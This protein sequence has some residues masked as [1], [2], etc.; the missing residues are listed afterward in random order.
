MHFTSRGV[1]LAVS[2]LLLGLARLASAQ[3][4]PDSLRPPR[5]EAVSQLAFEK[6]AADCAHPLGL[7]EGQNREY[8]LL[9]AKGKPTGS[10]RY[11]VVKVSTD[12]VVAKKK[13]PVVVTSVRLKCGLYDLANGVLQQQDL[14]Y[15]C[16][17]D[18][19]FTD[20][21]G[22]INYDGLKGFRDRRLTYEGTPLAWPNQPK[23]GTRL[24]TGGA[25]VLVSSPSVAIGR[26]KTTLLQRRVLAGPTAVTVPAGTFTCYAVESQRELATAARAD[27]V[28]KN[29]GRKVDYYDP[30]VG[31]VKAEYFDKAGKL[32]QTRVLTKF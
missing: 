8:Q 1:P 21:L 18:T 23:V 13:P 22:E 29:S 17:R 2:F 32:V 31:I 5:P 15:F 20:G 4:A 28:L 12:T 6:P 16:R 3:P 10:W 26:V 9:D 11:R 27:L 25:V 7:R 24:P 14:T 19:T 30:A